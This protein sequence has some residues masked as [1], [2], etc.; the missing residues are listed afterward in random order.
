MEYW[1]PTYILILFCIFLL[2]FVIGLIFLTLGLT[3]M[4]ETR[5]RKDNIPMRRY[6]T[7]IVAGV[8]CLTCVIGSIAYIVAF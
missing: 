6:Q 8:M 1:F 3:W 7:Y 5:E 4:T 2:I